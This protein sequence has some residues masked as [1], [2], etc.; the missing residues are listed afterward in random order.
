MRTKIYVLCEPDGEIRYIG[1]TVKSISLRLSQHLKEVR[2]GKKNHRCNWI[3]SILSGG[4]LPVVQFIG[5]V[6]GDGI[7]EEIAWIVYGRQEGWR[8]VN[9]TDGGEG[10][11]G[12]RFSEDAKKKLSESRRGKRS[13]MKGRHFSDEFKE[14]VRRAVKKMW[15]SEGYR[16]KVSDAHKGWR[17]SEETRAKM[18]AAKNGFAPWPKGKIPTEAHRRK[19]SDALKGRKFSEEHCRRLKEAARKRSHSPVGEVL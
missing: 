10:V 8:L 3:R 14:R 13:P 17:P 15:E 5:E 1:K 18:R 6:E 2:C 11:T 16:Q 9:G 4:Y 19:I 12:Y 7:R